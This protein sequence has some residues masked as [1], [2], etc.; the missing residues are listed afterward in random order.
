MSAMPQ[1]QQAY[2]LHV[3]TIGQSLELERVSGRPDITARLASLG[4]VPGTQLTVINY[5]TSGPLIVAMKD[6]RVIISL[7]MARSI[8]VR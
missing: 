4:F 5:T 6:A 1:S 8:W 3:A 7:D 2:P